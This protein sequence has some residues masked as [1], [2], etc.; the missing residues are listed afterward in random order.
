MTLT[1][2]MSCQ[3][4]E[5]GGAHHQHRRAGVWPAPGRVLPARELTS[6]APT[7]T[8]NAPANTFHVSDSS[9]NTTP[10]AIA[11]S[12]IKYV[13]V[14]ATVA[15]AARM[16]ACCSTYARPVPTAPRTTTATAGPNPGNGTDRVTTANRTPFVGLPE[17]FAPMSA[18]TVNGPASARSAADTPTPAH[19][20]RRPTVPWRYRTCR[21]RYRARCRGLRQRRPSP[22]LDRSGA[23]AWGA[24]PITRQARIA[25]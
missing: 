14:D 2:G 22:L 20:T 4:M 5:S 1:A 13:T 7:S 21:H 23:G 17:T 15:P 3:Q 6:M 19:S 16:T 11:N 18:S 12:G 25:P 8:K 24:R 9:R 10:A